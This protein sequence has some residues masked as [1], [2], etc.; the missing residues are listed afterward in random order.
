MLIDLIVSNHLI[1]YYKYPVVIDGSLFGKTFGFKP[2]RSLDD[3]FA[4]YRE[5]KELGIL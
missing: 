3:I 4:H 2:K 5:K 1:N